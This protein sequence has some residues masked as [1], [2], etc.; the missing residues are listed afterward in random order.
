MCSTLYC[1]GPDVSPSARPSF[2]DKTPRESERN[3]SA[4]AFIHN[5]LRNRM[6]DDKVYKS[7]YVFANRKNLRDTEVNV[8]NEDNQEEETNYD[9][10]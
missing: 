4:F 3:F 2:T 6:S 9:E 1:D 5:K 7:V 10:E 8:E